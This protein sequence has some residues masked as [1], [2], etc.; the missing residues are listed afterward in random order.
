MEQLEIPLENT[1]FVITDVYP[2]RTIVPHTFAVQVLLTN[3]FSCIGFYQQDPDSQ[4]IHIED[5]Q[6]EAYLNAVK[7]LT[8]MNPSSE[9]WFRYQ[10]YC[11]KELGNE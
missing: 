7:Q 10:E 4:V 8:E 2:L 6:H 9:D 5:G 1:G 11:V 3:G